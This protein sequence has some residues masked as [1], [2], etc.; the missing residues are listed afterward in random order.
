MTPEL[1]AQLESCKSLPSPPVVATKIIKLA[2][3]PEVDIREIAQVLAMDPAITTKI[4]RVVNS[5]MY[6]QQGKTENIPEAVVVLGLN[7]T[8]SLALSFS[9]IKSFHNDSANDGLD[10]GLYWRRAL[11]SATASRVLADAMGIRDT[12]ELFLASLIQDVGML[13]LDQ[14]VPGLYEN[15]PDQSREATIV[16]HERTKIGV[17]HAF[18][19]RWL[20]ERWHFSERLQQAVATSHDPGAVTSADAS[21]LFGRCVAL[22]SMIAEVF[23]DQTD[24]PQFRALA[25]AAEEH[26]GMDNEKLGEL[27]EEIRRMIPEAEAIFETQ[28]LAES[29]AEHIMDEAREALMIRNLHALQT[30]TSLQ[31]QADS[32]E[33]RTKELEETSRRDP[34]T[35]LYN[36]G[37]LDGFLEDAF[38][39]ATED[40]QPLSVAFADLDK[41]KSVNDTYGHQA[42]D[43][44]LTTT[45]KILQANVRS[46]DVVAR[47]GGEEFIIVFPNTD[48]E[49]VNSICTRIVNAFQETGHDVGTTEDLVVTI[50]VGTATHCREDEFESAAT[51]VSAADKALYTAKLKGRNRSVPYDQIEKLKVG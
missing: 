6:A 38:A 34:L 9:L 31:N 28:I 25:D 14:S 41:F 16:E 7:A 23:L 17:D 15:L 11:L 35:G 26:L 8:I 30:V 21:G 45:A 44:I 47:Y 1:T 12:E 5:P 49:L 3:D 46:T 37:F 50:S 20:L 24:D 40:N 27:L 33:H 43:Q 19:G 13:A 2:N 4:L 10:Y 29:S 39:R 42:G 18:V 32:L 51:F 22:T 36:R 48:R